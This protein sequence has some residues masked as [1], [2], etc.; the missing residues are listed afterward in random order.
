[1]NSQ[2]DGAKGGGRGRE[3]SEQEKAMLVLAE[4]MQERATPSLVDIQ[5]SCGERVSDYMGQVAQAALGFGP[6]AQKGLVGAS[7]SVEVWW[8]K[9]DPH[10]IRG[11]ARVNA[12]RITQ[13][14]EFKCLP[15]E[16]REASGRAAMRSLMNA[17][18]WL[19]EGFEMGAEGV[20]PEEQEVREVREMLVG[21]RSMG[22]GCKLLVEMVETETRW[23]HERWHACGWLEKMVDA[24][25]RS[26]LLPA[27]FAG[28]SIRLFDGWPG[29]PTEVVSWD[30]RSGGSSWGGAKALASLRERAVGEEGVAWELPSLDQGNMA[31]WA[32]FAKKAAACQSRGWSS[33]PASYSDPEA[34]GA[35]GSAVEALL[36]KEEAPEPSAGSKRPGRSL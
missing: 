10:W 4:A 36:L 27:G 7:A 21:F 24:A 17:H 35:L 8:D 11:E 5:R 19:S 28:S 3:L 20:E 18:S 22:T 14:H 23:N 29:H 13:V 30:V 16:A 25:A 26:G 12:G 32:A 6:A 9:S 31:L 2:S 33:M 15:G 1:M 34:R